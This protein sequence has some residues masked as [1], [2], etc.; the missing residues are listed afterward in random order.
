MDDLDDN[1][2]STGFEP[3]FIKEEEGD[4]DRTT[5]DQKECNANLSGLTFTEQLKQSALMKPYLQ[6]MDDLLKSCE[7]LTGFPFGSHFSESYAET[8]LRESSHSLGREDV[9]MESYGETCPSPQSYLSTTYIDTHMDGAGTDDQPAQSQSQSMSGIIN[10]RGGTTE[11]SRQTNMPLTSAGNKLSETMVEYEGQLLGMLVMLENCMEETGMDF[12]PQD[13]VTDESQEYVQLSKNPHVYKG[14]QVPIQQER[15]LKLETNPMQLQMWPGEHVEGDTVSK[16]SENR[17]TVGSATNGSAQNPLPG[18][19]NMGGF[20]VERF[21]FPRPAMTFDTIEDPMCCEGMKT[22]YVFNEGTETKGDVTAIEVDDIELSAEDRHEVKMD[23]TDVGSDV[24]E[25]GELGSRMEACIEEVERLEKRRKE[26]LK[27]VLQLRGQNQ[28]KGEGRSEEEEGTEERIDIKVAE[29]MKILKK[30]ENGRR[31]ERKKEIQSLKEER[32]E[33]ERRTWKVNV[34]RQGLQEELRR[35]RRKLFAMARNCAQS[36]AALNNQRREMEL[37]K[38]EEQKLNSLVLQL[39]E[40]GCQLKS[41]QKQQLLELKAKVQAQS[42]L[43]T[44]NTQEELTECRRH[45]CGDIQQYVQGGLKALEERYEPILLALLKRREATAGALVK[46][47]EQAQELKAQLGPFREEIQKLKLQK[48]CL[49]EKLKLIHIQ[50][51]EDVGQYKETVQFLE[52]RSRELKMELKTQK[53]NTN[54]MEELKD[55]LNKKL[56]L[57]RAAIEDHKCDQEEKT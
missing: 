13:W 23:T 47:K 2:S 1:I 44:S 22:G 39:T 41:A 9:R 26:L 52:E 24:N 21:K 50:R 55:R 35:L 19:E 53:R 37:L 3:L 31:E 20:S 30:E 28:E 29:L 51:R 36:K 54:E 14:T 49:E 25:L 12:E 7:E 11:V 43:L 42:S 45:S 6:E 57:Y 46:A 40:E 27:E 32:A 8:N 15:P 5:M 4:P 10:Q 56:L 38:R 48:A 17:M 33:E 18:Y 34:E 16:E